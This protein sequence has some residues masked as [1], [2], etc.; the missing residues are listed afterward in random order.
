MRCI[1]PTYVQSHPLTLP[2]SNARDNI[3]VTKWIGGYIGMMS[4]LRICHGIFPTD[5]HGQEIQSHVLDGAEQ[6]CAWIVRTCGEE[7]ESDDLIK[8]IRPRFTTAGTL[9]L[10]MGS[11]RRSESPKKRAQTG[12][13]AG[14]G[15]PVGHVGVVT[16]RGSMAQPPTL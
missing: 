7:L 10:A 4:H 14:I 16:R 15:S 13:G 5:E 9:P 12:S 2:D 1:L 6:R 11:G 8:G 3:G